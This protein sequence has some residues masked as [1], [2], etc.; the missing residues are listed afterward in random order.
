[1]NAIGK[2][3]WFIEAHFGEPLSLDDVSRVSG[4][5]RWHLSRSFAY[6]TGLSLSAYLRGRR[7]TEAA[8]ALANGAPDILSVALDAGYGSHEAF[9]RAF[10]DQFAATPEQVRSRRSLDTLDLLEPMKM[11]TTPALDLPQPT[12]REPGPL[13]V[14]GI[15]EFC[16][17]DENARI[18]A[19]WQRFAPNIGTLP[20]EIPGAAYGIVSSVADDR[21]GFDYMAGVAVR[22]LDELPEGLSGVR[23]PARRYA[24]FAHREHVSAISATCD[25]IFEQWLPASG[26]KTADG[27]LMLIEH[28]GPGFD[29]VTGVGDIEVWIP[30]K[31]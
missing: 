14:A 10:R 27:P 30:I 21:E 17:Y 15:R 26:E 24:C 23:L 25:A 29:P 31:G 19:Q 2:A 13:L 12:I 28:Y 7:L 6:R 3:L 5:S 22:S 8:K 20:D 18:P 9:T 16:G 4:L 11:S 1:M